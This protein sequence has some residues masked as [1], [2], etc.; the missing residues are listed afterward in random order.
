MRLQKIPRQPPINAI[1]PPTIGAAT[2][3]MPLTAAM[4]D[5]IDVNSRPLYLS[6]AMLLERTTPPAPEIPWKSR[7][8]T[9]WWMSA[10]KMHPAVEMMKS[11][12]AH[13]N[14]LR[15]PYLSLTGP[16]TSCPAARPTSP[17]VSPSCTNAVEHPNHFPLPAELAGTCP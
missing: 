11:N 4:I 12:I 2:V 15:R 7:I 1:M 5:I 6:A 10:A 13:I 17:V 8:T 16:N 3:A 14:G 9:N